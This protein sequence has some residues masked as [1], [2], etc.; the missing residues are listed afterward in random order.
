MNSIA[1]DRNWGH[2]RVRAIPTILI[3]GGFSQLV[4]SG[5]TPLATEHLYS[6]L[7]EEAG[8][9]IVH[10]LELTANVL[11]HGDAKLD[12]SVTVKNTGSKPY[13]GYVKSY[14][15]EIISRWNNQKGQPYHFGFLDYAIKTLYF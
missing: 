8:A 2:Y 12:I 11:G 3:D 6:P 14:V 13:L 9:R 5:S 15:T 4:G 7:I 1:Q 10:P